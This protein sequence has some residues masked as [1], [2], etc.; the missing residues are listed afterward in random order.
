MHNDPV[1]NRSGE[2]AILKPVPDSCPVSTDDG[3][4]IRHLMT[5]LHEPSRSHTGT[6][7]DRLPVIP[8]D[9]RVLTF[10]KGTG[11][12]LPCP[13]APADAVR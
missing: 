13:P 4:R 11:D 1:Q 8:P 5:T 10:H 9:N 2:R 7:H 6:T 12:L 3:N